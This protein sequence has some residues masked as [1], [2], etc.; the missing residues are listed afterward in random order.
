MTTVTDVV[1]APFDREIKV[2]SPPK[3]AGPP[4]KY[5]YFVYYW[6]VDSFLLD[7]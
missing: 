1:E 4:R 7:L 6:L 3:T 2:L 5:Y